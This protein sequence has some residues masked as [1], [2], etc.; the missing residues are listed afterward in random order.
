VV[1]IAWR[2]FKESWAVGAIAFVITEGLTQAVG[3]VPKVLT[4]SG[5]IESKSAAASALALAFLLVNLVIGAFLR[6]G[7]TRIWL[8][9]ARGETPT[10]GVLFSGGDRLGAMLIATIL[11]GLVIGLGFVLLI[12]PGVVLGLGLCLTQFYVIDT[13]MSAR[14]AMRA[15]W[16]ATKG[17]KGDLFVLGLAAVGLAL[18]GALM[19]LV[20]LLATVPIAYI[21]L[22][23]AYTRISGIR[24]VPPLPPL[25]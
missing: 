9:I 19:L 3:M 16:A 8:Q 13:N 25:S 6:V 23:V 2:R 18:L 11:L 21:A 10:L 17:Q 20:G 24:P 5:A 14:Q 22:A 15:S 4:S 1:S 12:V 7:L